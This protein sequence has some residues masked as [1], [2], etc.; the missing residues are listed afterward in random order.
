LLRESSN[1]R[2][3][4]KHRSMIDLL[5]NLHEAIRADCLRVAASAITVF[6][7]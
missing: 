5:V 1:A 4:C 3:S 7:S 2:V 6:S